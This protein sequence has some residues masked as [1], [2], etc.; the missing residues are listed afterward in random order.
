VFVGDLEKQKYSNLK[1]EKFQSLGKVIYQKGNTKI[2]EVKN[3]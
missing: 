2:Y 3:P 1:A